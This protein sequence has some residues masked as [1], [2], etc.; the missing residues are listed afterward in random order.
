[1]YPN[2]KQDE[3]DLLAKMTTKDEIKGYA[4]ASGMDDNAIK[5]IV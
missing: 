2:M 3:L 4:R 1:M 5:K